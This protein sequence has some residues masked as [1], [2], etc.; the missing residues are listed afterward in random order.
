MS[1]SLTFLIVPVEAVG[2]TNSCIGI[3]Q[4]LLLRGHKVVF[5]TP[6]SWKGKL[7]PFGFGEEYFQE[8]LE[9]D[10]ASEKWGEMVAAMAPALALPPIQKMEFL[11]FALFQ[12]AI[13]MGMESDLSL[14]KLME[15]VKP[16]LV[17]IDNIMQIP[18]LTC[19][20]KFSS[21]LK[22]YQFDSVFL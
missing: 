22:M 1:T 16:D 13:K 6:N 12:E 11:H 19:Q 15:R 2:H 4:Q 3:G 9:V 8:N 18:A 17:I 5:A 7:E 10:P 14:K 20:G 21:Q